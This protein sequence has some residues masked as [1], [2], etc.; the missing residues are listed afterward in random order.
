MSWRSAKGSEVLKALLRRGWEIK[1]Q[2][3]SH[4]TLAH[5]ELGDYVFSFADHEEIGRTM[6]AR[7]AKRTGLT[8]DDL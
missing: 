5:P 4:K 6:L 1:R 7:I 2:K 8:P 3:G